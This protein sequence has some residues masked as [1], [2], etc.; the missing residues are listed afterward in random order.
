MA[1]RIIYTSR[2][3]QGIVAAAISSTFF[4]LVLRLLH[5]LCNNLLFS[6]IAVQEEPSFNCLYL[7]KLMNF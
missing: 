5:F 1:F 6:L 4:T 3:I 2:N 7:E